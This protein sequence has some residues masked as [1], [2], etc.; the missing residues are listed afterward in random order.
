MSNLT[1]T[2]Q[3]RSEIKNQVKK[4]RLENKIPAVLYGHGFENQNLSLEYINFSK[5]YA[6]SGGSSLVDLVIDEAKPIKVLIQDFQ[7]GPLSNRFT[8][9]DLRQV[10]MTEKLKTEIKLN[11]VGES[12]AVKN[13]G[14]MLVKNLLEVHVEC[15]PQDLVN[16]IDVDISVLKEIGNTIH[17]RDLVAPQGMKILGHA[18]DVVASVTAVTVEEETPVAAPAIDLT[19]IKTEGEEKREKKAAEASEEEKK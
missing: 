12:P 15:L 13:L 19:Q 5:V 7:L 18:E 3:K 1:L 8:H 16:E 11:F 4:L 17:F 9:V 10:K 14:G 2:A 6:Q